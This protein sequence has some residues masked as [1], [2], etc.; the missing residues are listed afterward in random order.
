MRTTLDIDDD[1]L[2]VAKELA[3]AEGKSMGTVLSGLARRALTTPTQAG[4]PGFAEAQGSILPYP[5]P[6]H[7]SSRPCSPLAARS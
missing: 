3:K 2:A 6:P 5:Y 4:Q 1:V 7:H